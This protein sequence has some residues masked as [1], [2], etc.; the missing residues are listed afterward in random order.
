MVGEVLSN[1]LGYLP[2]SP[3]A[4]ERKEERESK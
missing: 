4:E 1:L 2:V 3:Q